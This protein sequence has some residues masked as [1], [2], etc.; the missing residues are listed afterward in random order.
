VQWCSKDFDAPDVP[1]ILAGIEPAVQQLIGILPRCCIGWELSLWLNP[2]QVQELIDA[3]APRFVAYG[4]RVYVHF[5][6]GYSSYQQENKFFADF[7]KMQVGKLTGTLHQRILG[8]T[9]QEYREASGG[10]QD[11]LERFAGHYFVPPDSGFGHPFDLVAWELTAMDQCFEGL[12]ESEGDTW[13][14]WALR[15]PRSTGPAGVVGVIGTG[16][17][18]A[19]HAP[20]VLTP[21][22]R[23]VPSIPWRERVGRLVDLNARG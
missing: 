7:W 11:V 3:I 9:P 18:R 4:C 6:Q 17:G 8:T 20:A 22:T 5:Q 12:S 16:N 1:S 14:T 10:L 21:H 2:T 19:E 13:G 15:T 23:M